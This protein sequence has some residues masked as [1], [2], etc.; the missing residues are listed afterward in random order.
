MSEVEKERKLQTCE[1]KRFDAARRDLQKLI[2]SVSV[3]KFNSSSKGKL[4]SQ[5]SMVF[6]E[7]R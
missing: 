2:S 6:E 5:E 3:Q 1:E 4:S 7:L